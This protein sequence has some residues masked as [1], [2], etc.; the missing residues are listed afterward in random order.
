MKKNKFFFLLFAFAAI[1]GTNYCN[2]FSV[3][4][5]AKYVYMYP[6]LK[7]VSAAEFI[8]LSSEQLSKL[9]GKRMNVWNKFSFAIVKMHV[10]HNLKK[11][12]A[13]KD[14]NIFGHRLSGFEKVLFWII[15]GVFVLLGL[16]FII[17]GFAPR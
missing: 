12:P 14:M 5:P 4:K 2:A 16:F 8:N 11:N 3:N 13:L 6:G 17:Y 1:A 10:R 9:T 7:D 15:L